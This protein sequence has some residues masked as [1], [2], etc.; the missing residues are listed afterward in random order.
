MNAFLDKRNFLAELEAFEKH[1]RRS[2]VTAQGEDGAPADL[3]PLVARRE[4]ACQ[5]VVESQG[6]RQVEERLNDGD[7]AKIETIQPPGSVPRADFA[8]IEAEFKQARRL[9]AKAEPLGTATSIAIP[10]LADA[11]KSRRRGAEAAASGPVGLAG[12]RAGSRRWLYVMAGIVVAGIAAFGLGNAFLS[13]DSNPPDASVDAEAGSAQPPSQDAASADIP[14]QEASKLDSPVSPPPATSGGDA[15]QPVD[16]P[17][18]QAETPPAVA[19]PVDT[20]PANQPVGAPASPIATQTPAEPV[21]AAA[22]PEPRKAETA[23]TPAPDAALRPSDAP[24][25]AV[26]APPSPTRTPAAAAPAP[27]PKTAAPA[28]KTPKPAVAAKSGDARQPART[29][30]PAKTTA[31]EKVPQPEFNAATRRPD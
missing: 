13:D 26:A 17:R 27:T 11:S 2:G 6:P 20:G 1:L 12:R 31:A 10:S 3:P 19:R 9:A 25:K 7:A 22:L 28:R 8:A 16:A 24:A 15:A 23:T 30:K 21:G 18:Q 29:A 14:A 4:E 5:S